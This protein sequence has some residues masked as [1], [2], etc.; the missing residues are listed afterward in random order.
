MKLAILAL[1]GALGGV[2]LDRAASLA[3]IPADAAPTMSADACLWSCQDCQ[4][5]C[6]SLA[7]EKACTASTAGCCAA[8]GKRPPSPMSCGC[9]P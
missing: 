7:C 2:T 9:R 8:F 1:C 4:R 3:P 6:S 5:S